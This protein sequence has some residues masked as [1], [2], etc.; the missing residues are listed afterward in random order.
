[1]SSKGPLL[2]GA[3]ADAA[4]EVQDSKDSKDSQ[5]KE[6]Q[7]RTSSTSLW[8]IKSVAKSQLWECGQTRQDLRNEYNG[9]ELGAA[10]LMKKYDKNRNKSLDREELKLLL[11][12][13]NDGFKV[14][15][16]E[17]AFI[18]MV[19][20]INKD[21]T[22]KEKEIHSG[23]RT[24][25]AYKCINDSH[26]DTIDAAMRQHKIGT[27]H[28]SP[29]KASLKA[30][31]E[32]LN[33]GHAVKDAEVEYVESAMRCISGKEK[34]VT[35]ED[36]KRGIAV[37]YLHIKRGPTS[38][39]QM[40][41]NAGSA[42]N[43]KMADLN[44][45]KKLREGECDFRARGTMIILGVT[46]VVVVF[47][48][49]LH[50]LVGQSFPTSW[51]CEQPILSSMIW[52]TGCLG[53]LQACALVNALMVNYLAPHRNTCLIVCWAIAGVLV[54]IESTLYIVGVS[55]VTYTTAGHCGTFLWHY[56]HFAFI[57]LPLFVA[58]LICC[59][60]PI[61]YCYLGSEEFIAQKELDE[62]LHSAA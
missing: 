17:V 43:N 9:K 13:F 37:W 6:S 53:F 21:G 5:K 25:Y 50:M 46:L 58:M 18:M 49:L 54:V 19:A 62:E 61:L 36:V 51:H 48:P 3:T 28:D 10:A 30:L 12:D 56:S 27:G 20:D 29:T 57:V 55:I 14:K 22:I 59:G 33:E 44:V 60:L 32:A 52:W 16:D 1:M 24:W 38:T 26:R 8:S 11:Q 31:L 35:D 34:D 2:E 47:V 41:K 45:A 40:L 15:E 42:V 4:K 23:F 7:S 39:L